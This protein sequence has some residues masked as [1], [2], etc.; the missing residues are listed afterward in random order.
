M[1]GGLVEIVW[2]E[3][4]RCV[5]TERCVAAARVNLQEDK[6]PRLHQPVHTRTVYALLLCFQETV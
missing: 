3:H 2:M 6:Q 1:F 5:R 4:S